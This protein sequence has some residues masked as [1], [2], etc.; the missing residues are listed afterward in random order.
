MGNELIV[1][2]LAC[3]CSLLQGKDQ[4]QVERPCCVF[5]EVQT[6][7]LR[8]CSGIGETHLGVWWKSTDAQVFLPACKQSRQKMEKKRKKG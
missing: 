2:A 3:V 8:S 6:R 1:V 4:I 7:V 5:N